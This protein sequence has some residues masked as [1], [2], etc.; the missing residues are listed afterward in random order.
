M[1]LLTAPV[2]TGLFDDPEGKFVHNV[3]LDSCRRHGDKIA[4]VDTSCTPPRRISYAEYGDLVE[5]TAHGLVAAGIR[6]GKTIGIYLSNCWEF[7]VAFHAA[8]MVGAVPTT[9]NPTYRDR[10][11]HHQMETSE[12][13]ALISD[14]PLLQGIDLSGLPALRKVYTIRNPGPG[15]GTEPLSNLFPYNGSATLPAPEHESRLTIATL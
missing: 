15:G 6:P 2:R 14:G 10:E 8:T 3:V 4:I 11:V 13:V 1:T 9:M 5:R 7:G 12:A